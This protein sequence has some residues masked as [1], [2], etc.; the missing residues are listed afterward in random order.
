MHEHRLHIIVIKRRTTEKYPQVISNIILFYSSYSME[1]FKS[2]IPPICYRKVLSFLY[3][4][5]KS[6]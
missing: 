2:P 1:G 5:G 4:L 3:A 6:F